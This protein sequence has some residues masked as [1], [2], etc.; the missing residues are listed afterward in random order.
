MRDLINQVSGILKKAEQPIINLQRHIILVFFQGE[1][2]KNKVF[3]PMVRDLLN[4]ELQI[5]LFTNLG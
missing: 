5:L 4:N 3:H 1:T 2:T